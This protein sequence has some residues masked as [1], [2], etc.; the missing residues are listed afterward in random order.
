MLRPKIDH[1]AG[2]LKLTSRLAHRTLAVCESQYTEFVAESWKKPE[3]ERSVFQYAEC[4]N[5]GQF[6]EFIEKLVILDL[7]LEPLVSKYFIGYRSFPF[8]TTKTVGGTELINSLFVVWDYYY[9]KYRQA[10]YPHEPHDEE[11]PLADTDDL[12]DKYS[13]FPKAGDT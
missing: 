11:K 7:I 13:P 8:N 9:H 2:V 10:K 3:V 1:M 12:G 4:Q 5:K 6:V